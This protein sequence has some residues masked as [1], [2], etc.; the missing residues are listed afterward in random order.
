MSGEGKRPFFSKI[1]RGVLYVIAIFV[2]LGIVA[3]SSGRT[4]YMHQIPY[5][6]ACGW[7]LHAGKALPHLFGKWQEAVL[8]LGCLLIA[9]V[10]AHHI[11]RRWLGEKFPVRTWRIRHTA[12]IFSLILLGSAA[13]IAASGVVH[14]M[15]WLAT[16]KVIKSN[17]R[18]DLTMAR[19]N[20]MQLMM[21]LLEYETENGRYPNSFEELEFELEA[22]TRSIRRLWWL[23]TRDGK[24]PE[25]WILLRP[26]S[27]ETFL[28]VV[29][30][31]VSPVIAGEGMVVV[32]YGDCSVRSI[33]VEKL[34]EV[35]LA[36]GSIKDNAEGDLKRELD[37]IIE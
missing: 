11:A 37:W 2:F 10:I 23:D 30:V 33:P 1:G 22:Y 28:G 5:H 18:S 27:S 15:F 7:F 25:P 8:P 9:A 3:P 14:Q 12:G 6:V 29:P 26:G 21:A 31:I 13:T 16:G 4:E 19:S 17:M 24:V 34:A 35:L 20:G 32:G 36:A